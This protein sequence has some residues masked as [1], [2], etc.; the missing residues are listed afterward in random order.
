MV[1]AQVQI[2]RWRV[3]LHVKE[4]LGNSAVIVVVWLGALHNS[5]EKVI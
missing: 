1:L 3:K 2:K 4:S 5:D